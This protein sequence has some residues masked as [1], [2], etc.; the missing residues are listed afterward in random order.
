MMPLYKLLIF[1]DLTV[2]FKFL[3]FSFQ[4]CLLFVAEMSAS[5]MSYNFQSDIKKDEM[6]VIYT[7]YGVDEKCVQNFSGA[8]YREE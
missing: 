8:T 4:I 3:N 5:I 6:V 2:S 1:F 7:T